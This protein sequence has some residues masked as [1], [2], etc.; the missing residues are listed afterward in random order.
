MRGYFVYNGSKGAAMVVKR[1]GMASAV[2][3]W[4]VPVGAQGT[5]PFSF[6]V[7]STITRDTKTIAMTSKVYF[8]GS[9]KVRVEQSDGKQV[10][11]MIVNGSDAWII[12][13]TKKQ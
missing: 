12:D 10:G 1:A 2:L 5:K 6:E 3:L 13:G 11:I 9:A 7:K 8:G 4:A